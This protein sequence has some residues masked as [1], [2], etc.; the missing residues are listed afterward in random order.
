MSVHHG[1]G[2][3]SNTKGDTRMSEATKKP[4]CMKLDEELWRKVKSTAAINGMKLA[5]L[6]EQA[7]RHELTSMEKMLGE[8]V[9]MMEGRRDA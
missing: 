3:D 1:G 7:L 9:R 5:E 4:V 6:V 8:E 2:H